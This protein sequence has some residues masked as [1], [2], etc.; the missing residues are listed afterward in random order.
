MKHLPLIAI[1]VAVISMGVGPCA[2]TPKVTITHPD[3]TVEERI[4][5]EAQIALYET[6]LAM[7]ADA[8][9]ALEAY[10]DRQDAREAAELEMH[11]ERQ[12]AHIEMLTQTLHELRALLDE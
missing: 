1:A 3:G 10:Q 4:D 8:L 5:V 11:L 6:T 2:T 9:E 12:R 7:A